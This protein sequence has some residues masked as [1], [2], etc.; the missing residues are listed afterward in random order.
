MPNPGIRPALAA[1]EIFSRAHAGIRT[2][3]WNRFLAI[4]QLQ[5]AAEQSD[6]FSQGDGS[7]RTEDA[8][9]D[10]GSKFSFPLP[11]ASPFVP[12]V[13]IPGTEALA[14]TAFTKTVSNSN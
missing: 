11:G 12:V 3:S 7:V 13:L 9:S 10:S 8:V 4:L 6:E 5:R 14:S 1:L 2:S